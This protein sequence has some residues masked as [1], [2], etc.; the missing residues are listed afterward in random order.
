[1]TS[2]PGPLGSASERMVHAAAELLESGGLDAVTTRAVAAAAGVQP[3]T[4]YRQFGDMEGLLEA[5][6]D[7]VLQRYLQDK[8]DL[9]AASGD[10]IDALCR[11]WDQHVEF[12]LNHPDCYQ[13]T[14]GR[15]LPGNVSPSL[16]ETTDLLPRAIIRRLADHG[17]LD[18]SV[19]RATQLFQ[20]CGVG[21]VITQIPISA[22]SRD[23]RLSSIARDNALAAILNDQ[24]LLGGTSTSVAARAVALREAMRDRDPAPLTPAEH[25]LL[26]EWLTAA[27]DQNGATQ[28]K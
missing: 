20:S 24:P 2:A 28:R 14:F 10:P 26:A 13:L 12:G 17:L 18:M 25:G 9:I 27:A 23:P 15:S 7:F 5:V 22:A 1:M 21:F 11:L 8:R 6:A 19:E 3:P 4:L 16:Q